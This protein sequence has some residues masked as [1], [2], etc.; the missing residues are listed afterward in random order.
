MVWI[1]KE[2]KEKI[3]ENSDTRIRPGIRGH[4]FEKFITHV[5]SIGNLDKEVINTLTTPHSLKLYEQA[6]THKTAHPEF[7][8]ECLE[9][10]GDLTLNK[11]IVCYLTRRFPHLSCPAGVKILTRLKINLISK[12]SFAEFAKRLHF[13]K[14]VSADMD[15]ANYKMDKTLEDVFE[16]FFGATETLIDEHYGNH[17]GYSQCYTIIETLLDTTDISLQYD[18]LFDAKTRL[19]E[20]FDQYKDTLGQVQ[21]TSQ[22][23]RDERKHTV[24]IF[25]V[26]L[27]NEKELLATAEGNLKADTQQIAA[28]IAIEKLEQ[29]GYH[30]ELPEDYKRFCT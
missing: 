11:A 7:N 6:F 12:K 16:A 17:L 30:R 15:T 26:S 28:Q 18:S 8:Y 20:L 21:Y 5:L 22:W 13:W 2:K 10:L 1:R 25:S 23:D 4:R 14:F 9:F 27:E 29:R 19:K 3:H 24:S